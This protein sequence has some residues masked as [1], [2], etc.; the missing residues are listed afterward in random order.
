M[1]P[2]D[3]TIGPYTLTGILVGAACVWILC[4]LVAG[5]IAAG[6]NRSYGAWFLLGLVVGPLAI[7]LVSRKHEI[8]PPDQ[9]RPCPRCGRPIR[10][11][12]SRCPF[13]GE[14]LAENRA[15]DRAAQAGYVAGRLWQRVRHA[16]RAAQIAIERER[17][18]QRQAKP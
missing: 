3:H 7:W 4:A 9:A 18:R 6:K 5:T 12:A 16:R 1:F 10:K 8:I 11:T 14:P 17:E 15:L 2:T 13:C